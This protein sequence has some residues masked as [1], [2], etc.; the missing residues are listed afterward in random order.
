[1]KMAVTLRELAPMVFRIATSRCFS[2][3]RRI[4]VATM[5]SAATSTIR[6]I[7]SE[8]AIFSSESAEKRGLFFTV[9]S[10]VIQSD[11]PAAP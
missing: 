7:A 10:S 2:M 6:P 9:Q 4:S 8:T 3:T 11:R 5:L 1:M